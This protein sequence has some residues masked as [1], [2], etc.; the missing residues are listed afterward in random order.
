[1][2][3]HYPFYFYSSYFVFGQGITKPKLT[4]NL[5]YCWG[6]L[7]TRDFSAS[8]SQMLELQVFTST[9]VS[10]YVS[11]DKGLH[12]LDWPQSHDSPDTHIFFLGRNLYFNVYKQQNIN[13][14][15][16]TLL[17]HRTSYCCHTSPSTL[18]DNKVSTTLGN[19]VAQ[20]P[21]IWHKSLVIITSIQLESWILNS[22]TVGVQDKTSMQII[23][24]NT[25]H[26]VSHILKAC[27]RD[28]QHLLNKQFLIFKEN[29]IQCVTKLPQ[30]SVW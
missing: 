17:S 15:M 11:W 18:Q 30:V 2:I 25:K 13:L 24:V 5:L 21:N 9:H 22:E 29:P 27:F 14:M 1:M 7:W 10:L 16:L 26:C 23:I 28:I 3:L 8:G 19:S 20:H 12:S 6:W 4:W